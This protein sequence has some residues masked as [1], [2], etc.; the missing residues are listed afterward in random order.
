ML[1]TYAHTYAHPSTKPSFKDRK[2][3]YAYV[4]IHTCMYAPL[5]I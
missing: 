2:T 3:P 5:E 1:H 4:N